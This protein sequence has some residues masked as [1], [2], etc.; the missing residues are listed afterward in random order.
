MIKYK[1]LKLRNK[2]SFLYNERIRIENLK[3]IER[4]LLYSDY[5]LIAGIDE[6]G[7][8]AIAGPVVA[9]AV[10][11]KDINSFFIS[12]LKD[13][14]KLNRLKRKNISEFIYKRACDVGIGLV[15]SNTIDKINIVNSTILAMKRAVWSLKKLPDYL[16]IDALTIPSIEI[17]QRKIIKGEDIS[18][19]IAS[20]SIIAKVYRDNIMETL[21]KKYPSYHFDQNKGYGTKEH[22]N[23]IRSYGICP[24]HRK[25]FKGVCL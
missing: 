16:L 24:I 21:H 17:K 18:I 1:I 19:S 7:R 14:K 4:K 20:A 13:S 11:I 10:V 23:L 15:S 25:T 22:F 8:G 9:A 2:I 5:L 3:I 12:E 6:V